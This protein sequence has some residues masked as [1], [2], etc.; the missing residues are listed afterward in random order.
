MNI[1][2]RLGHSKK[3]HQYGNTECGVYSMNYIIE[4]LKGKKLYQINKKRIP[5]KIMNNMRAHLYRFD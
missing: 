4:S 1:N 2:F 3:Q 5:D